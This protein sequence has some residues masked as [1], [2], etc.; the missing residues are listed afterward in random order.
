MT[1]SKNMKDWL[2]KRMTAVW[3]MGFAALGRRQRPHVTSWVD[4]PCQRILVVAPHPDDESVG[5]AGTIMRHKQAGHSV[6][7]AMITDGRRSRA[8]GLPASEMA[9]RRQTEVTVVAQALGVNECLWCGLPEGDW[10]PA[11]L[12]Q[13]LQPFL[14]R[15]QPDIV[16]APSGL[17]FHPEHQRVAAALAPILPADMP[18]RIYQIQVPLT[19][20]LTNRVIDVSEYEA[21]ITAV[22]DLYQTQQGSIGTIMRLRHYTALYYGIGQ[23]AEPF[24]ELN[25]AQYQQLSTIMQLHCTSPPLRGVRYRSFTDPLAYVKGRRRRQEVARQ[26]AG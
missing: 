10:L 19:A 4:M 3:G 5:C 13:Q 15:F 24:W 14:S 6:C 7:L 21:L 18:V 2:D 8:L 23:Y 16:Y 22:L 20:T 11:Q 12:C 25:G 9:R 1:P 17:D 26:M